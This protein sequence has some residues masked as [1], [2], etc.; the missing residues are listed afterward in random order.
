MYSAPE[1]GTAR[2]DYTTKITIRSSTC[3]HPVTLL[4]V[5]L[6]PATLL[7]VTLIRRR[8]IR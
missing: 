3:A 8:C 7:P 6:L 1:Y 5:T 4:P 2:I